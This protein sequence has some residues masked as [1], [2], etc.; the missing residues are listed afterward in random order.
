MRSLLMISAFL[1]ATGLFAQ[2]GIEFEKGN[3]KD[4]LA[5][6]EAEDKIIF[7]DAYTT[8]CGPCK[9]MSRDVFTEASVGEFYNE[10]FINAKID[11]EAGEGIEL[12]ELYQ[13][14]AY[15]SLLFI[16]GKGEL[17]H[18]AVGYHDAGQFI[19][20]G[21]AAMDP[22]RRLSAMAAR[23]AKGDRSPEFLYNYAKASMNAM[24]PDAEEAVQA[25]LESKGD[26]SDEET[27][28]L[29][30]ETA[31][32]ADS[33]LFDYILEHREAFEKMYGERYVISKV[34]QMIISSLDPSAPP[35]E[36]LAKADA[37][38]QKAFPE[39]APMMSANFRMNYFRMLGQMD[40]FAE[41][42]VSYY[43]KY[44]S[45]SAME[46]NNIA[47]AFFENVDD[48]K[49]LAKAIGWAKQSVDMEDAYYNNDTLASLYYKAGT[50]KKAKKAAEHA[51]ELAKANG[52]DYSAT[53]E[54][55][56][57]IKEM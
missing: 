17:L 24:S 47:W 49:M 46:L 34:Q 23:Y 28:Q 30:F 51:I 35:E 12:A 37:Q 2:D 54:L 18:R 21:K 15:P 22:S 55:L 40:K 48:D 41:T 8:W 36:T 33:P 39:E 5:A 29:I 44:G 31:E 20:L 45:E 25:Y 26:W 56:D 1:F 53:K 6:A 3:W 43:D 16:D 13:V 7:M 50:K 4:I 57:K 38:F 9:M 32:S 10:N 19:G 42:A 52:E 11:M 14:R 27:M